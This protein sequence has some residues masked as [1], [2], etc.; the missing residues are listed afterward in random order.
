LV[1]AV[2]GLLAVLAVQDTVGLSPRARAMLDRF[3]PPGQGQVSIAT[4]FSTDSA[5]LGEQVDLVTAA[6]FPRELRDRLRRPPTLRAP[7]LGGLWSAQPQSTPI[8]AG[9]RVVSGVVYDLFVAH[10]TLFPLSAGVTT[11]PPAVLTYA[12]PTSVSFFAPEER[13]SLSSRPVSLVVRAIPARAAAAL[14]TGPTAR[15]LRLTWRAPG[16]GL[17]AAT[18]AVVELVMAGAGNV[19]LWPEPRITWPAGVR[20]YPEP[21]QQQV[22]RPNGVV[23]GE[24]R[25]RFTVVPDSAGVVTLPALRYPYFDPVTTA[26]RVASAPALGLV[27]RESAARPDRDLLPVTAVRGPAVTTRAVRDGWPLLLVLALLPLLRRPRR[28]RA[29]APVAARPLS[30]DA[31]LRA[32]LGTPADAA[33]ERIATALRQRGI[34]ATAAADVAAWVGRHQRARYGPADHGEIIP[35][36]ELASVLERLRRAAGRGLVAI[37]LVVA[38]LAGQADDPIAR[39]RGG[40][41]AGAERGFQ[42]Q[43]AQAP[44]AAPAW[45]N[46]AAARWVSGDDV[47][48]VAAWIR[49]LEL[50]PRD[51]LTRMAW[52]AAEGIPSDVRTRAPTLPL[53]RDELVLIALGCWIAAMVARRL[54]RHGLMQALLAFAVLAALPALS[55]SWAERQGLGLVRPGAVL[56]VSPLITAPALGAAPTWT[57]ARPERR[58]GEWVLVTLRSGA[59][60]WLPDAAVAPIGALD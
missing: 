3:P 28:R 11:S 6:W 14:G 37:L 22:G 47:G 55:R 46:L 38:P 36:P 58:D 20:V 42:A 31:T 7:S 27:V 4:R 56:R 23:T 19:T 35:P 50:A 21:V 16:E 57:T 32:L 33:P 9:T 25:F 44:H 12:V 53:S 29:V 18:P 40:D 2:L 39:Y 1:I 48:A 8:L 5:W 17:R 26:V 49:A 15:G 51:P 13:Q 45:R 10:Q 60:G 43:V 52:N 54:G 41:P 34:P 30:P 59:R 24:K